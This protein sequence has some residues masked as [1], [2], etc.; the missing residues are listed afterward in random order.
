MTSQHSNKLSKCILTITKTSKTWGGA[1]GSLYLVN[2]AK[3]KRLID[4]H[5]LFAQLTLIKGYCSFLL[6]SGSTKAA[7]WR[8]DCF[9][10][11]FLLPA[12]H[13]VQQLRA[14]WS[15]S[16]TFSNKGFNHRITDLIPAFSVVLEVPCHGS[17]RE[18]CGVGATST[19]SVGRASQQ[20]SI[21]FCLQFG[22]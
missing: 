8:K 14:H 20:Q 22:S 17:R 19:G 4:Q 13:T 6:F 18:T 16:S 2:T 7:L 9:G 10:G 5:P 12:P 1:S 15:S 11:G 21:S 3:E